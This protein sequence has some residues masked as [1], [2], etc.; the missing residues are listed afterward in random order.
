MSAFAVDFHE[1]SVQ[2]LLFLLQVAVEIALRLHVVMQGLS[3]LGCLVVL[4]FKVLQLDNKGV[5][6]LL[7]SFYL[8]DVAL[9]ALLH[10]DQLDAEAGLLAF[11]LLLLLEVEARL[12]AHLLD[13]LLQT[14]ILLSQLPIVVQDVLLL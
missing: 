7:E 6:V 8:V 4:P 10:L 14:L 1:L 12:G 9:F 2:I 5:D 3:R 11:K 13:A